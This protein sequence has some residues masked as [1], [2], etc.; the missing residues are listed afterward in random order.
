MDD[1]GDAPPVS[2]KSKPKSKAAAK[3]KSSL[4]EQ[5]IIPEP[6]KT[7]T[8]NAKAKNQAGTRTRV[9]VTKAKN[10]D[11]EKIVKVGPY[12]AKEKGKWK[13]EVLSAD[14]GEDREEG[15]EGGGKVDL[16]K[17]S[18]VAIEVS[19]SSPEPP[20]AILP[21]RGPVSRVIPQQVLF[22]SSRCIHASLIVALIIHTRNMSKMAHPGPR[23]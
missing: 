20:Q 13:M 17:E 16:P 14:E 8:V 1:S 10:A 21:K 22:N 12:T 2:S 18:P 11:D 4:I 15:E 19:S 7:T 23:N 9:A 5:I 6:S 3:P